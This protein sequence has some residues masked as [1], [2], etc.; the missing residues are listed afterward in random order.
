MH[1]SLETGSPARAR[2]GRLRAGSLLALLAV[3][4]VVLV[5][6]ALAGSITAPPNMIWPGDEGGAS[7]SGCVSYWMDWHDDSITGTIG[8]HGPTSWCWSNSQVTWVA[9]NQSPYT[10]GFWTTTYFGGPFGVGPWCAGGAAADFQGNFQMTYPGIGGSNNG[11]IRVRLVVCPGGW[12]SED[13]V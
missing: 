13:R 8:I 7:S 2:S 10:T 3:V 9:W 5:P 1:G 12:G 4:L 6:S 11:Y